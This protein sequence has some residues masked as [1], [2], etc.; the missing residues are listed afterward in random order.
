VGT[1]EYRPLGFTSDRVTFSSPIRAACEK[2]LKCPEGGES[3]GG[4]GAGPRR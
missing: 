3:A 1:P 4:G 2:I